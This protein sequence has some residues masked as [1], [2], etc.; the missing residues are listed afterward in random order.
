[1]KII[2][3]TIISF[4]LFLI[5]IT[6]MT[7]QTLTAKQQEYEK[8]KVQ[9]FTVNER[10]NLL[11]WFAERAKLMDLSEEKQDE[12]TGVLIFYFVKMSRL[13]DKDQG[14]SK[15]EILQKLDGLVKKQDT[16]IKKI[17]TEEQFKIH[18]KN[19]GKLLKSIKLRIA[20]TEY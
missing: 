18:Q 17:L 2:K 15:E 12:Y 13:D 10:D 11:N 6:G 19:Y 9:I 4:S 8:N 1:M 14:N 20:Q 7:A 5:A 3:L 16:E